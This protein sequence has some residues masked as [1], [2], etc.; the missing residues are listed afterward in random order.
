[1]R[2]LATWGFSFAAAVTLSGYLLTE[3]AQLA[4][5]ALALILFAVNLFI[6][7][8]QRKR[9]SF[10][11]A[12]L[13]I[14]FAYLPLYTFLFVPQPEILYG[15]VYEWDAE[16][17][18]FP[19]EKN[20]GVSLNVSINAGGAE[21]EAVIYVYDGSA[22]GIKPGDRLRFSAK[23]Y[24]VGSDSDGEERYF[25]RGDRVA[26][27]AVHAL[28]IT[29]PAAGV[30][31][32]YLHKYASKAIKDALRSVFP[33]KEYPLAL[34]LITGNKTLLRS[35]RAL[36]TALQRSGVYHVTTVSG[37]HVSILASFLL[38]LFGKRRGAGFILAPALIAF[39]ALAGFTPSVTRAV[40][41]QLFVIAAPIFKREEDR[42]TSIAAALTLIIAVDPSS[43]MSAGLQLS[44][45][46]ILG[47]SL[48]SGKIFDAITGS[49]R[50]EKIKSRRLRGAVIKL[51]GAASVTIGAQILTV[52]LSALHFGYFSLAALPANLLITF[53]VSPAFILS[54][55]AA[56][57]GALF[58][59]IGQV[60]AF[61]ASILLKYV[62]W[63]AKLLSS[64]VLSAVYVDNWAII[65][66][67]ILAY[68]AIIAF[69]IMRKEAK[70][71]LIPLCASAAALA[72][73]LVASAFRTDAAAG[74]E[75]TALN[76]GQGQCVVITS[77]PFTAVFDCGSMSN[78]FAGEECAAF[79]NS[80]GRDSIDVL[81]I[82]HYHID[83]SNGAG[84]LIERLNVR[85][86]VLPV[87]RQEEEDAH[88]AII[89][90]AKKRKTEVVYVSEDV[91]ADLAGTELT[92]F[93]PLGEE[94]ENE[95][96]LTALISRD[97]FDALIT[98][99]I[100]GDLERALA[101]RKHIPDIECLVASHHGSKYSSDKRFLEKVKPEIAII[102][103]GYNNFGHPSKEAI[104][105]LADAGAEI[106][107]TDLIG[108]I[109]VNS[110][111]C[112][113][114]G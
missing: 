30:P 18:D 96:C 66:W 13:C 27:N 93:A 41:M 59:P 53:A 106:Y 28:E 33:N 81:C 3:K 92:V 104:A 102:S 80:L 74:F 97:G 15:V 35:D 1:M 56:G 12:G 4:A 112:V 77:G 39:A 98:A 38:L 2:K 110:K 72:L 78:D 58:I 79:I 61:A 114:Y 42:L 31:L 105:R 71:L 24:A 75:L 90:A 87:P 67:L 89:S 88:R 52:P 91:T 46:A 40:I 60:F 85:T 17:V 25:S 68:A 22:D 9:L 50:L 20:N 23:L 76:V 49:G 8:G 47:I 5:A 94:S 82:S 62:S 100:D 95:H 64:S 84:Q 111:D 107:R 113:V 70:K 99:D 32:R 73:I 65:A 19:N 36:T 21:Q 29:K 103:V 109:S 43:A 26:A 16:A 108:N 6:K 83:H 55:L 48:A 44:F 14:G 34:A 37:M 86:L 51:C 7:H 101:D 11:L 10:I 63:I 54:A 69:I 45:A 57:A